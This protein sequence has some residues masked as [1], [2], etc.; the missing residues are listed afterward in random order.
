MF[1]GDKHQE[2]LRPSGLLTQES[3]QYLQGSCVVGKACSVERAGTASSLPALKHR[4]RVA[5]CICLEYGDRWA[6]TYSTSLKGQFLPSA[7]S[8]GGRSTEPQ[9]IGAGSYSHRVCPRVFLKGFSLEITGF[10][11]ARV[12][13]AQC[14]SPGCSSLPRL[15]APPRPGRL[16]VSPQALLKGSS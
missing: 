6:R 7:C 15:E 12:S 4:D 11:V 5:S 3:G 14:W 2:Y 8:W 13:K 1:E 9:A 10:N 16:G